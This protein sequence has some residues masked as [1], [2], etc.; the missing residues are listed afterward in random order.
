MSDP[1]LKEERRAS[2]RILS[3]FLP[4]L[5]VDRL[6]RQERRGKGAFLRKETF[7]SPREGGYCEGLPFAIVA[8]IKNALRVVA[9]DRMAEQRGIHLGTT[10]AD[11]RGAVP[12]LR[13]AEADDTADRALLEK[14]ADWCDRY[15]PLVALDPPDGLFLDISGC[16][17]L[18]ATPDF[19]GGSDG[20]S[21][22]LFDCLH[23]LD[24]QGFE[25]RAAIASTAGAA[26]AVARYGA[27]GLVTAGE[28]EAT[29]T[30]LPVAAL[31]IAPEE[32]ALLDR[33][34]LKKIGQ[35][36]GLPRAPLAARLGPSLVRR[37][38][39]MLGLEDKVL[40][41]RR[42][43]PQLMAER[44]FAEPVVE[45]D[46]LLA[47]LASLARTL[48]STMEGRGMGA[49]LLE[50][51]FFRTDGDV[52]R[53]SVGT[54]APLRAA[55]TIAMLFSERLSTLACDWDA[56]FGFDMVRLAVMETEP[57]EAEQI[58]LAGEAAE[59]ADFIRLI[60]RLGARLGPA[61]IS[62][63]EPVDTHIPERAVRAVPLAASSY[64]TAVTS[65]SRGRLTTENLSAWGLVEAEIE[66]P[67]ERPIRLFARPERVEVLAE[68]PDG[69][70]LRFRWRRVLY[71]VARAEGPERLAPEWWRLEDSERATRDYFRVEDSEGRRFWLFR[72]GLY[73]RETKS[74]SWYLHGLFA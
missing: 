40:S 25:V 29:V 38:D 17:H 23:R 55:D 26:W 24:A 28:E 33:V 18:F 57:F 35:L 70:P 69:P 5:A 31:R 48:Q 72:E 4:R 66:L 39:Q 27:G 1:L 49:R 6:I 44:C 56:G 41:P 37:L 15:T 13:V 47:T 2:G 12:D 60:D 30:A 45:Q 10:L 46:S 58:D 67:P 74:P 36:I 21:R 16:T 61:R 3:L 8:K 32:E 52:T 19:N 7:D 11:A 20:E 73:G 68:V 59:G 65:P 63:Y 62:Q 51:S 53:V 71:E 50:A 22:L 42:P 34:G 54:A 43:A 64:G 14:L 9:L